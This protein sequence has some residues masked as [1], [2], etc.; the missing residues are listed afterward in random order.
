FSF[1]LDNQHGYFDTYYDIL[2]YATGS[3]QLVIKQEILLVR[4][5]FPI[6]QFAAES[7]VWANSYESER[8][9]FTFEPLDDDGVYFSLQPCPTGSHFRLE[10]P[11]L[12]GEAM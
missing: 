3:F 11:F 9:N 7:L 8:G 12:I 2:A 10:S 1:S 5:G 6:V 4:D